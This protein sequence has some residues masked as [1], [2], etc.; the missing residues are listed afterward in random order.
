M[1]RDESTLSTEERAALLRS[2]DNVQTA[3]V[4]HLR[5]RPDAL[6]V[7]HFVSTVQ[8]G[9]DKVFQARTQRGAKPDCKAG[10]S[11]CCSARVEA[12]PAEVF[13]IARHVSRRAG[14]ALQAVIDRLQA[15]V[16]GSGDALLW[17]ERK[18]C[19]FL[20]Q[21]LCSIYEVRPSVCRKGHSLD[22]TRCESGSTEIP[23]DLALV[24]DAEALIKGASNA[25]AQLGFESKGVELARAVLLALSDPA[26]QAR[27]HNGECVFSAEP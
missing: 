27:W 16:C 18:A 14:P 12:M 26:A 19:A 17:R 20:E 9:V 15:Q 4:Q 13:Q 2:V 6:S 22:V 5:R 1:S 21:G 24:L 10:C 3:A 8:Q 7:I 25:Y 11:H 23:E